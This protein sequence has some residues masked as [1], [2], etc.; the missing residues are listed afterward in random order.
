MHTV[1]RELCEVLPDLLQSFPMVKAQA[2]DGYVVAKVEPVMALI[3]HPVDELA[4]MGDP[5]GSHISCAS[6]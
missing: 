6:P 3:V 1:C 2:R 4:L 5:Q